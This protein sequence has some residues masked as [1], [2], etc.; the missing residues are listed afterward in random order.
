MRSARLTSVAG[1]TEELNVKFIVIF[2]PPAVGKM[3]VGYELA[4][5]TG[6]KLFHNHMSIDL[7]L[8]FFGYGQPPFSR[9]VSEFRKRI[10]EE[11][12]DSELSG[13]IFT[14]VWSLTLESD[15]EFVDQTCAIFRKKGGEI[16]FVELEADLQER[17]QRNATEFRLAQKPSKRN[18]KNSRENLL[19]TE[20]EHTMNSKGD[21]FYRDNY[22][23]IDNT[24]LP[25]AEAAQ[26]IID[27]FHFP[28]I[29]IESS[30]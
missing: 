30:S 6:F 26:R 17:L 20:K 4:K 22:V 18:L 8:N 14:F 10:F 7:A 3:T 19:D 2:G 25:A 5:R 16:Y 28:T 11:V 13:L 27:E 9:L 1:M 29:D 12:A 23:K 21:F 15:R 24:N